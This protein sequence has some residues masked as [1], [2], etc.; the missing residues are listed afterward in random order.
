MIQGQLE[1][2]PQ[3][4]YEQFHT[5]LIKALIVIL[6]GVRDAERLLACLTYVRNIV[7]FLKEFAKRGVDSTLREWAAN[8]LTLLCLRIADLAGNKLTRNPDSQREPK[9]H[10]A[11]LLN[12]AEGCCRWLLPLILEQSHDAS[13][14]EIVS[15]TMSNL[16]RFFQGWEGA[17]RLV[18]QR[19][20]DSLTRAIDSQSQ[21]QQRAELCNLLVQNAETLY[22][23]HN[24]LRG[25]LYDLIRRSGGPQSP[26]S[27]ER[28]I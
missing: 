1:R 11:E 5:E 18:S 4:G 12:E 25:A 7:S 6:R 24:E 9:E 27:A 19:V 17:Q 20:K 22:P 28:I 23:Y 13:C 26:A 10:L 15:Q 21:E 3:V 14:K 8:A 2:S 16:V